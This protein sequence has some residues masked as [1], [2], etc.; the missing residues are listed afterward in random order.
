[1]QCS[2]DFVSIIIYSA[3]LR[4]CNCALTTC[5]AFCGDCGKSNPTIIRSRIGLA[6][7]ITVIIIIIKGHSLRRACL[8]PAK[9]TQNSKQYHSITPYIFASILIEALKHVMRQVW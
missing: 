3:V 9:N 4:N 6:N 1:M 2:V 7:T 5:I 8:Q